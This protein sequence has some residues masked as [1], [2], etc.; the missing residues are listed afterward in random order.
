MD[1][2]SK[3]WQTQLEW[4]KERHAYLA[5]RLPKIKDKLTR[6]NSEFELLC[7]A[8]GL[9]PM[10]YY[11]QHMASSDVQLYQGDYAKLLAD[12]EWCMEYMR[13]SET[14]ITDL[15]QKLRLMASS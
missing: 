13:D 14:K 10:T 9:S 1:E 12:E 11:H 15:E 3:V 2:T 4:E 5:G 8:A 6:R 7:A